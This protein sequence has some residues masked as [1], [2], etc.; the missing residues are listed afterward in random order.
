M[1]KL[2]K[3]FSAFVALA[4]A[5]VLINPVK[6]AGS[7]TITIKNSQTG[8]TYEAYQVFAGDYYNGKLSNITWGSGVNGDNLLAALKAD[9]SA[10]KADFEGATTAED[11]ANVVKGYTADKLDQFAEIVGANLSAT[12]TNSVEGTGVYTISGL[13]DGYYLVK[14]KDG[15]VSGND[16][17]TKYIIQVVGNVEVDA[18]AEV[19]TI[20]KIIIEADDGNS[21][22]T[23]VDVGDIVKFQ[24]N[25]TVPAMDGYDSYTYIVHDTMSTGLTFNNDVAVTIDGNAY[26]DFTVAQN[27]QSFTITFNNFINQKVNAGKDIV[28]TYSATLNENALTTNVET[29]TVKLEY[30]NNPNDTTTSH[31]PDRTVYV[32]DFDIVID[33]YT[34]DETTGE[35]LANAK[36]VLKNANGKYY[37]YDETEKDVVWVDTIEGATEVTTD[38]NGYAVF[39]GLD[40]GTYYLVET[41]APAGYNKLKGDVKVV[42]SATYKDDGTLASSSATSTNNGQYTQTA[43]VENKSGVELPSTGG[44]GTTLFYIVGGLL[45]VGAAILLITKK[46]MGNEK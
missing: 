31:T 14:D 12:K 25:S 35:R 41:E 19:P 29:N 1:K 8:H 30:S 39:K 4:M 5:I 37:Y 16:A 21:K 18:K 22:G 3:T 28:I 11:V 24:L 17:Y 38:E 36:F 20:D 34:G 2:F 32:Y 15:S 40:T 10:L 9:D 45:V 27:G 26:T 46:R 23:S 7:N 13:A 6:A 43:G 44:M 42:I 33:K